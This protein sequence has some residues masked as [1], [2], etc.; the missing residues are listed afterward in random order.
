MHI[1]GR[2]YLLYVRLVLLRVRRRDDAA[3]RACDAEGIR[4]IVL[5]ADKARRDQKQ[6]SVIFPFF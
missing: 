6:V 4:D 1:A 3:L 2:K 5:A